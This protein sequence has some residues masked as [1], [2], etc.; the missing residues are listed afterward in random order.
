MRCI[1]HYTEKATDKCSKCRKPICS[2]CKNI[3]DDGTVYCISCSNVKT[4]KLQ[5]NR[6]EKW[7]HQA[8]NRQKRAYIVN[9]A[10][11]FHGDKDAE[12]VCSKCDKP[13]CY[14]CIYS[15][16]DIIKKVFCKDCWKAFLISPEGMKSISKMTK[17]STGRKEEID[18]Q[19]IIKDEPRHKSILND[20][21]PAKPV[22]QHKSISSLAYSLRNEDSPSLRRVAALLLGKSKDKTALEH[23]IYALQNDNDKSVRR[24]G[25][26]SLLELNDKDALAPLL[27]ALKTE[28][29]CDVRKSI[30]ITYSKLKYSNS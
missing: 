14:S 19:I 24:Q 2:K 29:D 23:L 13:I 20:D 6:M 21:I 22:S 15:D 17:S 25:A 28:Q 5:Q 27:N 12:A 3:A 4:R 16:K 1:Y 8:A 30:A 10:C 26:E 9:K 18:R 7:L 11:Y